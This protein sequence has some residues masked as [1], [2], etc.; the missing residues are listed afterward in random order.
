MLE[1]IKITTIDIHSG[2]PY[3]VVFSA[4]AKCVSELKYNPSASEQGKEKKK[5]R[6]RNGHCSCLFTTFVNSV[7]L[8][9][10]PKFYLT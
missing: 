8:L 6:L 3:N 9:T 4:G 2:E 10:S 7:H 5:I 1:I